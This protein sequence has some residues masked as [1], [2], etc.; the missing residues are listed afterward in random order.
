MNKNDTISLFN[1]KFIASKDKDGLWI[2]KAN[3]SEVL[4][5]NGTLKKEYKD[6]PRYSIILQYEQSAKDNGDHLI[7]SITKDIVKKIKQ[8]T[9]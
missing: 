4:K 3:I 7:A 9:K 5:V 6:L 8:F 2:Y 1:N